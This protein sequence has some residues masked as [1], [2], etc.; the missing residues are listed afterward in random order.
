MARPTWSWPQRLRPHPGRCRVHQGAAAARGRRR[1]GVDRGPAP[2][3]ARAA[4]PVR[5]RLPRALPVLHG[6]DRAAG[7]RVGRADARRRR[8]AAHPRRLDPDVGPPER[9]GRGAVGGSARGAGRR[10]RSRPAH[11]RGPRRVRRGRVPRPR[12]PGR[13]P[14]RGPPGRQE[15]RRLRRPGQG[16]H[17]AQLLRHPPRPA[18]LHRRP[19]PLQARPV[20]P[21]PASRSWRRSGSPPTGPTT[22]WCCR[23]TCAPSSSSSW[24][25]SASG[26]AGWRSRSRRW[27]GVSMRVPSDRSP[28]LPRHRHGADARRGRPRRHRAGQRPVRRLRA[29]RAGRPGRARPRGRPA[30]RDARPAGR[31]STPAAHLAALS[32]SPAGCSRPSLPTTSRTTR[33]LAPR[34]R[35]ARGRPA[36]AGSS[37]P[38]R[39]S[40]YGAQSA[41]SACSHEDVLLKPATPV[42]G[43]Q[44]ACRGR[45]R[46]AGPDR[47]FVRR[48]CGTP[49]RWASRPGRGPEIALKDPTGHAILTGLVKVLSDGTP[50]RPPCTPRISRRGRRPRPA[51][52]CSARRSVWGGPDNVGTEQRQ[53]HGRPARPGRLR[54]DL[55]PPGWRS[56]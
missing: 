26:A 31:G 10:G 11:R 18:R 56:P 8:A 30:R 39:A 17:A 45:P 4:H 12:R 23:G 15:G 49:P 2:A 29:R 46:R 3:D 16:Q 27:K 1:V 20:H 19:Q 54:G 42:R 13:V 32:N 52:P 44:G 43:A 25:T 53:Q 50:W 41:T 55:R 6:A 51:G 5:H 33:R 47:D 24:P 14:H 48:S 28:G 38:R 36:C 34:P 9:G 40:V 35:P 7:A 22:C 37:T 21:G